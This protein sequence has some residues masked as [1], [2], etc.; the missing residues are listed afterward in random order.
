[1]TE[2]DSSIDIPGEESIL[3]TDNQNLDL[4][5]LVGQKNSYA[6]IGFFMAAAIILGSCVGGD[7]GAGTFIAD[8]AD[9]TTPGTWNTDFVRDYSY[10]EG[11]IFDLAHPGEIGP[12]DS[13]MVLIY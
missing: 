10:A 8:P 12:N 13:V 1:M 3:I 7:R 4:E 6:I 11:R 5:Q 9:T 2:I